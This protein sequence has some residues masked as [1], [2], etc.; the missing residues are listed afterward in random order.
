MV[1]FF[2]IGADHLILKAQEVQVA[3][4][5]Q[6]QSINK[7]NGSIE[8]IAESIENFAL[9]L[10]KNLEGVEEQKK[11]HERR[12]LY[13]FLC[14]IVLSGVAIG[15][16]FYVL[17]NYL[18]FKFPDFNF[19][20]PDFGFGLSNNSEDREEESDQEPEPEPESGGMSCSLQDAS[21]VS[22]EEFNDSNVQEREVQS[23]PQMAALLVNAAPSAQGVPATMEEVTM[24]EDRATI[25]SDSPYSSTKVSM[26]CNWRSV[27]ETREQIAYARE[28]G[29]LP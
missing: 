27:Q 14:K 1:L 24:S 10:E 15:G 28:M 9:A 18:K 7:V 16:I 21:I 5:L 2:I 8:I 26:V 3:H 4:S 23:V 17:F 22:S 12:K 29:Y 19:R 20:L 11:I 6:E 25:F 13:F